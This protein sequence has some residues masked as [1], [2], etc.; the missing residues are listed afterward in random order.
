[1]YGIQVNALHF[2]LSLIV[3]EVDLACAP[4]VGGVDNDI[5]ELSAY[6]L[7]DGFGILGKYPTPEVSVYGITNVFPPL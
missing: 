5:L 2:Y 3:Q 6:F 4:F 1:M 7:G